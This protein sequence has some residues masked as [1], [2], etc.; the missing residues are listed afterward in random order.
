MNQIRLISL[1]LDGTLLDSN[2]QLPQKNKMVLKEASREGIKIVISTGSPFE[3]I[4]F[5]LLEGIEISYAITANGS[6]IYEYDSGKCIY[7]ETISKEIETELIEYLLDKDIHVDLFMDGKGHTPKK[8][9]AIIEK[10]EVPQSRKDYLLNNRIWLDNPLAYIKENHMNIQKI[11]MNFYTDV[12]GSLK[13]YDEVKGYLEQK[14]ML[15]ITTG[16]KKNLEITKEGVD[17]GNAIEKLA[18]KIRI[19]LEDIMAIG[20]SRNDLM[21]IEK[22]GM[23]IAMGNAMPEVIKKAR[24]ITGTNDECGVA[25]A[26]EKYGCIK[27]TI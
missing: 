19:S 3:L 25:E 14:K 2:R 18:D 24:Y 26:I 4:P 8:C 23:G 6:A 1:D 20:D 7:E 27:Q 17:K 9:R 10:L 12:D 16:V 13:D 5:E 22:V 15:T 21:I 11:T